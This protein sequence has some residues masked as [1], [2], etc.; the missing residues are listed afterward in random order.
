M[1]RKDLS[2]VRLAKDQDPVQAFATHR[3]NQ[4]LYIRILPR[5]SRRDRSVADTHR[6]HPRP[7]DMSVGTV[8]VPHQVGGSCCPGKRLG[9]LSRQPL[10]RRVACHLEPQQL[11][12]AVAQDQKREQSLKGQ[13]WNPTQINGAI[14]CA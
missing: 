12:P 7:E 4:T 13:G 11:P 5:R 1:S 6:P 10:R 9:D 8:V 2:Q 3:A 14:A